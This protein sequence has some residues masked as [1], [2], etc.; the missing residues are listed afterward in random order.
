[1]DRIPHRSEMK[2]LLCSAALLLNL[3]TVGQTLEAEVDTTRAEL[4]LLVRDS[5]R[6]RSHALSAVV[7][8]LWSDSIWTWSGPCDGPNRLFR[9]E[10]GDSAYC[11]LSLP[12][13]GLTPAPQATALNAP[14]TSDGPVQAEWDVEALIH[15]DSLL[16]QPRKAISAGCYPPATDQEF[17]PVIQAMDD[18][19]FESD[20]CRTL[21]EASESLCLTRPQL[22]RAL[23]RI[24][25]EDRRLDTLTKIASPETDWPSDQLGELFQLNF[26]LEQAL[27]RFAKR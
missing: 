27:K 1:M 12:C 3:C 7:D 23:Q 10:W 15:L 5:I 14:L 6:V 13:K 19:L 21:I 22:I 18:A 8:S 25:S 24:P 4:P 20:K 9:F 26:I 11:S 16:S 17:A 2:Y